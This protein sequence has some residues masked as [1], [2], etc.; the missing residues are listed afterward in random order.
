MT[1]QP[2]TIADWRM[3][4]AAIA[5]LAIL[6]VV[7][8]EN[9]FYRLFEHLYIG[10][11][12]GFGIVIAWRDVLKELWWTPLSGG[13]WYWIFPPLLAALWYT[14]YFPK[15][16]WMSRFLISI[17][18]GLGAGL[19]FR[20]FANQVFPQI[21]SSFLPLVPDPNATPP[22]DWA[23]VAS[24]AAFLITLVSV[25]IYFA[26]SFRHEHKAIAGT[27]RLGRWL[28]MVAFGAT[29]GSTVMARFSLLIDRLE[30]LLRDWLM[31]LFGS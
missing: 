14:I 6:S 11:A 17:L 3:W 19:V 8:R 28:L 16:S 24:N 18:F 1:V 27:A 13:C 9:P 30:F 12:T 23:D 26:F 25:M 15:Y 2:D 7:Y 20:G 29:F 31:K 5:T 21:T 22:T 4:C 10:L